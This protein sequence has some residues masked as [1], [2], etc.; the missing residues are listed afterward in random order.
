MRG[1]FGPSPCLTYNLLEPTAPVLFMIERERRIPEQRPMSSS[2]LSASSFWRL[3]PWLAV[4]VVVSFLDWQ[5]SWVLIARTGQ[6]YEANPLA[7]FVL[8]HFGWAGLGLFKIGVVALVTTLAWFL[9][10]RR[11]LA[12]RRILQFAG[13]S[14]L[15]VVSYSLAL[16]NGLVGDAQAHDALGQAEKRSAELTCWRQDLDDYLTYVDGL[17]HEVRLGQRTLRAA[18][19]EMLVHLTSVG[20]DPMPYL[21]AYC[22]QSDHS[23]LVASLLIRHVGYQVNHDPALARRQLRSLSRQFAAYRV[24]LPEFARESFF[25]EP[26]A[27]RPRASPRS[28]AKT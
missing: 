12:A 4:Y 15:A 27:V 10:C 19:D 3:W 25:E 24:P 9:C 6:A 2:L 20:H 11:P 21:R 1:T 28:A 23:V 7:A 5:L 16:R 13:L 17:A 14:G 18:V 8:D 22:Q 26:N